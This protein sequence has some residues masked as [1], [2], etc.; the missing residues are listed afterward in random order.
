[1]V[2]VAFGSLKSQQIAQ[3]RE[4]YEKRRMEQGKKSVTASWVETIDTTS[5]KY[6]DKLYATVKGEYLLSAD[7]AAISLP[8]TW[9]FPSRSRPPCSLAP[10]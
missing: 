5:K 1:M 10:Q 9:F 7:A 2:A 4:K 6:L 8:S 3:L